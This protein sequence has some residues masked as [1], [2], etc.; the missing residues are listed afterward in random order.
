MTEKLAAGDTFDL[1][2]GDH[3]LRV[4]SIVSVAP[5]AATR[6][7]LVFLHDSLGCITVW[8]DFPDQLAARLGCNALV[9]DRRGYGG[10]SPFP[11]EARDPDYLH[12]EAE[13]LESVLSATGANDTILFGHS[14]GGSIALIAAAL[15]PKRIRAVVTEGAH[16]FV[17]PETLAGIREAK[18]LLRTSDLRERLLRHHGD[19][20]DSVTSAWIDTW[21]DKRFHDWNIES[22]LPAI[23]CPLLVLQGVDDEYGT[24][25]QVNAIASQVRGP[26]EAHMI[27]GAAHTPH[28]EARDATVEL[29]VRFLSPLLTATQKSVA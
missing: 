22:L 11:S 17:E 8:R 4:R 24:E 14:D 19:K 20:T 29:T 2:L 18:A 1:A 3:T 6:P 26:V 25:A 27:A 5:E 7:V 28:R 10:S 12:R 23:H 21:L 16:V 9:Y 15:H 13:V